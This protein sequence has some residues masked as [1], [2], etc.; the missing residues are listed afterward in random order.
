MSELADSLYKKVQDYFDLGFHRTGTSVDVST[1]EW[2]EQQLLGIGARFERVPYEYPHYAAEWNLTV[3]GKEMKA[4]PL[5]YEAAGSF[6]VS[7]PFIGTIDVPGLQPMDEE[8]RKQLEAARNS[9]ADSAVI[10]TTG[11]EGHLVVPNRA[12]FLGSGFPTLLVAGTFLERLQQGNVLATLSAEI[13]LRQSSN[14]IAH[15]GEGDFSRPVIV[16]TSLSGWFGCAGERGTGIAIAIELAKSLAQKY[17]VVVVGATG[18][19]LQNFGAKKHLETM[20]EKPTAVIH[21]GSSVAA[22]IPGPGN[23]LVLSPTRHAKTSA[24]GQLALEIEHALVPVQFVFESEP[25]AFMGEGG[26]WAGLGMPLLSFAGGF[27]LFH[28]PEDVP[29]NATS[30]ELL[31]VVCKAVQEAAH[32]FVS[33]AVKG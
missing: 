21:L 2:F 11:R 26:E 13:S 23:S 18:H 5:Y 25:E 32:I 6:E 24:S 9:G 28:T 19:E 33:D 14:V 8:L 29:Q 27:R 7:S 1:I 15:M 16:T 10:A 22:G 30:P 20:S 12:P 31:E 3:D 4:L 17:P